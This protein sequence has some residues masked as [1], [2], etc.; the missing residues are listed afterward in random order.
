[1]MDQTKRI[2][3]YTY[4][5]IEFVSRFRINKNNYRTGQDPGNKTFQICNNIQNM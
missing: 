4:E 3:H 5:S 1:M 2:E